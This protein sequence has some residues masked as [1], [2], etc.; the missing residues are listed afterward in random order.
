LLERGQGTPSDRPRKAA[1]RRR[2]IATI[3]PG[4]VDLGVTKDDGG[5]TVG[6]GT[7]LTY[8]LTVEN[9]GTATYRLTFQN[10]GNTEA[11]GV[12]LHDRMP[13][14]T[15]PNLEASTLGWL[16][17][18]GT[19]TD[20]IGNLPAGAQLSVDLAFDVNRLAVDTLENV[21]EI[22]LDQPDTNPTPTRRTTAPPTPPPSSPPPP[23]SGSPRT[24]T[25]PW[26]RTKTASPTPA[27]RSATRWTSWA[28]VQTWWRASATRCRWRSG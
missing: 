26:T 28:W 14:A 5:G 11:T 25:S 1:T 12:V 27:T 3:L 22:T 15:Q 8:T 17:E 24:M 16:C 7:L 10:H 4:Q 18:L 6:P 19:C 21:P 13:T 9:R 23:P 20:T 2:Y